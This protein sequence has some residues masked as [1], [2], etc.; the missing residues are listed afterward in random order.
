MSED[1]GVSFGDQAGGLVINLN[2]IPEAASFETL[3]KGMYTCDIE[4]LEFVYA[5]SSG[6]PMWKW[7]LVIA[8]HDN[9]DYVGRKFFYNTVWAGNALPLTKKNVLRIFPELAEGDGQVDVEGF[10]SNPDNWMNKRVRARVG[11]QNYRPEGADK[12]EVRN[13]VKELFAAQ[14]ASG[15]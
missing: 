10:P 4:N 3:P 1:Q 11:H 14:D 7:E 6:N 12:P 15:F 13:N 5:Q 8:E 2:D 9:T